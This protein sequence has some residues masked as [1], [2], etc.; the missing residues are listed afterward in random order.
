MLVI[1]IVIYPF[2]AALLR[3][4]WSD[5]E[6]VGIL[7]FWAVA[8]LLI[9]MRGEREK[10]GLCAPKKSVRA[11]VPIVLLTLPN[12]VTLGYRSVAIGTLGRQ[13]VVLLGSVV[14]E[15]LVFRNVL[16]RRLLNR[17]SA[18]R[19]VLIQSVV[20][21][22]LHFVNLETYASLAYGIIQV[23]VAVGA[24]F[25]LGTIA[26][27]SGSICWCV[28]IHTV[29]NCSALAAEQS[30]AEQEM[31]VLQAIALLI[32]AVFCFITGVSFFKRKNKDEML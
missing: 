28:L 6:A 10:Y 31:T 24:G 25:W 29:V 23:I 27:D 19:A 5:V 20:F 15:E 1:L 8:W 21:G 18:F 7:T 4:Y 2:I 32:A 16:L 3:R 22:A 26:L 17:N 30:A 12:L 11:F 13:L 9:S 14:W